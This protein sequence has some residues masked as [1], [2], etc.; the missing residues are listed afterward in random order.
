MQPGGDPLVLCFV[1]F[2]SPAHAAT[3][4]DAL[5]GE[6]VHSFEG[7]LCPSVVWFWK[8]VAIVTGFMKFVVLCIAVT[9]V[10]LDTYDG[11][12]KSIKLNIYISI[13]R[14]ILFVMR[15]ILLSITCQMHIGLLAWLLDES[16]KGI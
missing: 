7:L 3:A 2:L 15:T 1:D 10:T 16:M 9:K 12:T 13:R 5:Q 6:C 8:L 14:T 11:E 4:M